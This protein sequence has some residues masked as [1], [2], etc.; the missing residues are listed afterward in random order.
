M[1]LKDFWLEIDR[2]TNKP[3]SH[4]EIEVRIITMD[5]DLGVDTVELLKDEHGSSYLAIQSDES[6]DENPISMGWVGSDGQP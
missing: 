1:K 2:L 5:A 3:E 6:E 4:P